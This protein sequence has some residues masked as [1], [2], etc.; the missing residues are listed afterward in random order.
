MFGPSSALTTVVH[1]KHYKASDGLLEGAVIFGLLASLRPFG[2][3]G[4]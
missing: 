2:W 1:P 4:M 3:L